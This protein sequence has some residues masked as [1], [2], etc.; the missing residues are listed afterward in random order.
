MVTP[1]DA[2]RAGMGFDTAGRW[3][4]ARTAYFP[5][6][7][8]ADDAEL[9]SPARG[10]LYGLLMSGVLWIGILAALRFVLRLF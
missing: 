6:R 4:E 1:I 5:A 10:A 9:T 8:G 7:R 2:V 3:H